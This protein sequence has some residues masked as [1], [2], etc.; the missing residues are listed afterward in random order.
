MIAVDLKTTTQW[1]LSFSSSSA[2]VPAVIT[3]WYKLTKIHFRASMKS[4][5]HLKLKRIV[6][7]PPFH[8]HPFSREEG[9]E[10]DWVY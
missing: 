3:S 9:R 1:L 5:S 7:K 8:I 6:A 2:A 10:S 4:M